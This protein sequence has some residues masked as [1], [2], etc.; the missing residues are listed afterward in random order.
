MGEP[1]GTFERKTQS[2]ITWIHLRK[3]VFP[4]MGEGASAQVSP[5][6]QSGTR[7]DATPVVDLPRELVMDVNKAPY[8]IVNVIMEEPSAVSAQQQST[9][10]HGRFGE[11]ALSETDWHLALRMHDE[12]LA[13][14]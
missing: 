4:T 9:H 5:E 13:R 3:S 7:A 14:L 2:P 8:P 6:E 1:V 10:L 12:T 11:G